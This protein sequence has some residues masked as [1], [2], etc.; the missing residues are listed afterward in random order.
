MVL[1]LRRVCLLSADLPR[2]DGAVQVLARK[3]LGAAP[4]PEELRGPEGALWQRDG[5]KDAAANVD[6]LLLLVTRLPQKREP[7]GAG[8]G[9]GGEA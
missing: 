2:R 7:G 4:Q 8:V 6:V 5:E 1:T 3:G 9:G